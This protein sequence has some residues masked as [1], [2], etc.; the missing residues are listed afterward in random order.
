[1]ACRV[2]QYMHKN[3]I[4]TGLALFWVAW[5]WVAEKQ[6]NFALADK[7]FTKVRAAVAQPP[8]LALALAL[9]DDLPA[10]NRGWTWGPCRWSCWC[11]CARTHHRPPLGAWAGCTDR[12]G[13][14]GCGTAA[15]P[16]VP[17]PHVAPLAAGPAGRA[18]RH[19]TVHRR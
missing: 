3:K 2:I 10:A 17:A 7:I 13:V 18:R 11:R 12:Q 1:V 19:R 8:L 14:G 6:S 15:A 9:A 5:A 4:G 16:S